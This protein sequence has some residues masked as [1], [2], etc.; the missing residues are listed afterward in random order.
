M[1]MVLSADEAVTTEGTTNWVAN[2]TLGL[3][4][5]SSSPDCI[6]LIDPQGQIQ[7][8]NQS[9]LCLLEID[10]I[11]EI[12]GKQWVE[13][14]PSAAHASVQAALDVARAGGVGKFTGQCPTAKGTS[15]W[16]DV[17]V[18]PLLDA[19]QHVRWLVAISRDVT[20]QNLAEQ[21][22]RESE[23]HFRALA[24]NMAQLAWMADGSGSISWYNR[25]WY[26]FTG[27]SFDDV[28]GWG[29][30]K[31][32]HPDHVQRVVEKISDH[33]ARGEIWEDTFPLLGADGNYRWFL[34]RAV[35]IRD[36]RGNVYL[37]CG[38][39]TDITEQRSASNRLR[40]LAR[41]IE[42]SHEAILIW[43]LEQGIV[44]W[45]EGC[46]ALYGYSRS[47]ALGNRSHDLLKTRVANGVPQFEKDLTTEGTWS[48]ELLQTSKDGSQVWVDSRREL[49]RFG[50]RSVVLET[51]RDITERRK[52]DQT[53]D[54]L[55][56]EL[57]HR[58]KNTL[59][60]VQSIAGQTARYSSDKR[61]F[62]ANFNDRLQTLSSAHNVLTDANWA[63]AEL[64]DLI[65]CQLANVRKNDGNFDV[66]GPNVVLPSQAALQISLILY[67]LTSNASKYGSLTRATGRVAIS[68]YVEDISPPKLQLTWQESGG[69]AVAQPDTGGF[70]L[71]LINRLGSQPYLQANLSFETAGVVCRI[72]ADVSNDEP[73][74]RSYFNPDHS[75]MTRHLPTSSSQKRAV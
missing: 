12:Q 33:F 7:F 57:N 72:A 41:L 62:L 68:W 71:T 48:G 70:G 52:A 25:R 6:K 63:G 13:N 59:A 31:V 3:R 17:V 38:T 47:E 39:N 40:Q 19:G 49:F 21:R 32:H 11:T 67:E 54:L 43:D 9:G 14:W 53:R 73:H 65:R 24:D 26:E 42:L 27:T 30:K 22:R 75:D 18:S 8:V 36:D 64:G 1:Q 23:Q 34:S 55:V 69:P 20:T 37:W 2:P 4:V 28:A 60:I 61:Q 10:D 15:K 5:L 56:G 74:V 16:W 50:D 51:N 35:P 46:Q 29:W 58:V 44:L 66:T 45:N